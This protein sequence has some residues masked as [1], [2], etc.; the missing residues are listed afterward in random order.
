MGAAIGLLIEGIPGT[1]KST[2]IRA[3][4][5]HQQF[6]DRE[7]TSCL[8]FGEEMTQRT[9]EMRTQS[10]QISPEDHFELLGELLTLL[11]RQQERFAER[12]WDGIKG[13]KRI[14]YLLERFHLT[15]ASY[16]PYLRDRDFSMVEN[17]L[18]RLDARGCLLTIE[19]EVMQQRIIESRPF[20]PWRAYISRYGK[21]DDEIVEH[22]WREQEEM[23]QRAAAS[24]LPWI[25]VDT[26]AGRWD[27]L[28]PKL[29][30]HWFDPLK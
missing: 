26:T 19:R 8:V 28:V 3:I 18:A 24:C 2:L 10:G 7:D 30:S 5:R 12:G 6:L 22:Y 20:S 16:Y 25:V 27:E 1:G 21:T 4:V 14:P 13:K 23:K 15:H 11:E 29:L 17:R 9:L